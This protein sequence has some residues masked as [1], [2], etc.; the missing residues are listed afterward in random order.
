MHTGLVNDPSR[1]FPG[2][3]QAF[4]KNLPVLAVEVRDKPVVPT[5]V[6]ALGRAL[7]RF[8][9]ARGLVAALSSEQSPLDR[10]ELRAQVWQD[11]GVLMLFAESAPGACARRLDVDH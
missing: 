3:V 9:V 10:D 4:V 5:E 6:V 11:E 7:G 8:A 2:D 1:H